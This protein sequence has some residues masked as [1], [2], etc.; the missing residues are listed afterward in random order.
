MYEF[1]SDAMS[2]RTRR[3]IFAFVCLLGKNVVYLFEQ[4]NISSVQIFI[5]L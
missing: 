1:A 5:V 3:M 4:K 2:E